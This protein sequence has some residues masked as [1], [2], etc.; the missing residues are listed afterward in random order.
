MWYRRS[1]ATLSTPTM[2]SPDRSQ[3]PP[4]PS[5]DRDFT[6]NDAND[7]VSRNPNAEIGYVALML[8]PIYRAIQTVGRRMWRSTARVP[9]H[10]GEEGV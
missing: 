10:A 1:T 8:M 4:P 7:T 9:L 5:V 6:R 3:D 2:V